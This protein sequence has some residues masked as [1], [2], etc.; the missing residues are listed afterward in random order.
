MD[1]GRD[2]GYAQHVLALQSNRNGGLMP[3]NESKTAA[4]TTKRRSISRPSLVRAIKAEL[5]VTGLT[6]EHSIEEFLTAVK[7]AYFDERF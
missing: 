6:P 1:R 5:V 3:T 7:D 4:K 2:D